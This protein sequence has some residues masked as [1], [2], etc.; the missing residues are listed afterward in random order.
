MEESKSRKLTKNSAKS[1]EEL[2]I[3]QQAR[4]LVKEVYLDF[5]DGTSC[6]TDFGFKSQIQRASVSVMNNIA[7]G[8]ERLS[9]GDFA[10]FLAIAKGSCGEVRSMYYTAEDLNYVSAEIASQRRDKAKQ[11]AAGIMSLIAHLRS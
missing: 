7:E 5:R 1:F 8:F 2:W 11:F 6:G 3:W 9:D 4:T 10:R